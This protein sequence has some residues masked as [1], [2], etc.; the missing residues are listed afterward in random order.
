MGKITSLALL[1]SF[2][3]LTADVKSRMQYAELKHEATPAEAPRLG[4]APVASP[5][6][7]ES[8]STPRP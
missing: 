7:V 5:E 2:R 6:G 1:D 8:R 3:K 4:A